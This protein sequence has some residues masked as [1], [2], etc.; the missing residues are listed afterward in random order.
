MEEQHSIVC[1]QDLA[2]HRIVTLPE[3]GWETAPG[4]PNA[5]DEAERA[6]A[7]A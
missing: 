5:P 7:L 4:D 1:R 2:G 6:T 3:L